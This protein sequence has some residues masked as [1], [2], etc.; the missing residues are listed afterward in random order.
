MPTFTVFS[1]RATLDPVTRSYRV[2]PQN[3]DP[4][5]N[6]CN[7]YHCMLDPTGPECKKP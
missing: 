2:S 7:T 3:D 4:A 5:L 6:D 1:R